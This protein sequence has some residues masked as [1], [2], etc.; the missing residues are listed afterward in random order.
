[1]KNN[2]ATQYATAFL[3]AGEGKKDV[4]MKDIALGLVRAVQRRGETGLLRGILREAE[5]ISIRERKKD[6]VL[7]T[8]ASKNAVAR[9]KKNI[10]D[11]IL[12]IGAEKKESDVL[13]DP[14]IIGGFRILHRGSLYDASYRK[15]L[16]D[17]YRRLNA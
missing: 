12:A 3:R 10:A 7:L 13:I 9:H 16:L 15:R 1:M 4:E 2:K 17:L 14:T 8:I 6:R 5:H 11:G